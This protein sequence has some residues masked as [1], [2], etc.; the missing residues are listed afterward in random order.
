MATVKYDE[1]HSGQSLY[2]SEPEHQ[3][4][5]GLELADFEQDEKLRRLRLDEWFAMADEGM[6]IWVC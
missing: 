2:P 1:R 3:A 5:P 4:E 6:P